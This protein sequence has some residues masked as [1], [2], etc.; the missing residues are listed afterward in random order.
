[1]KQ[2]ETPLA[3]ADDINEKILRVR[4]WLDMDMDRLAEEDEDEQ[5]PEE[6]AHLLD[7]RDVM[8]HISDQS[9][10]IVELEAIVER[11]PKTCD[12]VPFF[13]GDT[14]YHP[15]DDPA[16]WGNADVLMIKVDSLSQPVS[17][18]EYRGDFNVSGAGHSVEG[19]NLDFYSNRDLCP[20]RE[21]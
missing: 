4:M 5:D 14:L 2:E 18:S 6:K 10:R 12:G 21:S 20:K 7:L 13:L 3:A 8:K 9:Q 15:N 19:G 16:Y 1:V 17:F 11:L